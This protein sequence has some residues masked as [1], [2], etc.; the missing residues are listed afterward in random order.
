MT[1]RFVAPFGLALGAAIALASPAAHANGRFPAASQLIV[2]PTDPTFMVLRTTYGFLV[3]HDS[4]VTWDWVCETA[5]GY[6]SNVEDPPIGI[7]ANGSIVAGMQEGLGVS[8]N[9]GCDWHFVGGG[10]DKQ[11]IVDVVV[12][13]DAPHTVLALASKQTG[14]NDAGDPTYMTQVFQSLDDGVTWNK[15]GIPIDG[16]YIVETLEVAAS[17]PHRLYASGVKGAGA[18]TVA[19]LFVSTNDGA[20]WT[21]RA[22]PFDPANDRAPFVSGVDPTNADRVY[23]RTSGTTTNALHVSTNAGQSFTT[24]LTLPLILGFAQSS[25]GATIYAGGPSAGL[26][27]GD[28]ATLTFAKKSDVAVGCLTRSGSKIF[29]CSNEKL[30]PDEFKFILGESDDDGVTFKARLHMN[31]LRGPLACAADASESACIAQWPALKNTL[32]ITDDAGIP[33]GDGGVPTGDSGRNAD[34]STNGNNGGSTASCGC[35][36]TPADAGGVAGLIGLIVALG[37][38]ARRGASSTPRR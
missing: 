28:R 5:I 3:S 14:T 6:G 32:G 21:S 20:A 9:L 11:P 7:T 13:P 8:S 36:A 12:R 17:D 26:Y 15:L 38:V 22:V 18:S 23:V 2:A 35:G 37:L 10:L 1:Q 25:D 30:P 24:P 33:I 16:S 27:I 19:T 34:A 31:G 4:G 29:S